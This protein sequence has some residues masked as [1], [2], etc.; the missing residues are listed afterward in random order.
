[1]FI[2]F[3]ILIF[4]V[5]FFICLFAPRSNQKGQDNSAKSH[6]TD[7]SNIYSPKKTTPKTNFSMSDASVKCD[8]VNYKSQAHPEDDL[9]IKSSIEREQY[10]DNMNAMVFKGKGLFLQTNRQRKIELIAFSYNEAIN[11][12]ISDGY[13][14]DKIDIHR[15]HFDPPSE[16]QLQAMR[17]HNDWIPDNACSQD[18]SAIICRYT[19][20]DRNADKSLMDFATQRGFVFSYFIGQKALIKR[21]LNTFSSEE[22]IA[23]YIAYVKRDLTGT[24]DLNNFDKY[25]VSAIQLMDNKQF[26]DSFKRNTRIYDLEEKSSRQRT[27][28]Y[29]MASDL[30]LK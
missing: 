12:L 21:L 30:I 13:D 5:W 6:S 18:M 3:I 15:D 27:L 16:E 14:P 8:F 28:C 10:H 4:V 9:P 26:M 23:L 29:Q 19:E 7:L 22:K 17:N 1:M 2:A 20:D 11:K 24:W 25:K